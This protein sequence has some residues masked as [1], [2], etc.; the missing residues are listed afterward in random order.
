MGRDWLTDGRTHR[1][2]SA[3]RH[4][5]SGSQGRTHRTRHIAFTMFSVRTMGQTRVSSA[6]SRSMY[7]PTSFTPSRHVTS[8]APPCRA[9][10]EPPFYCKILHLA[11]GG[12]SARGGPL[13]DFHPARSSRSR[14]GIVSAGGGGVIFL[15]GF[16]LFPPLQGK[17]EQMQT[18]N[19]KVLGGS[20][21]K[22]FQVVREIGAQK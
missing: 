19:Q 16:A 2:R 15:Y 10:A 9:L 22:C 20:G 21:F 17:T 12:Q 1:T 7:S 5:G 11:R 13:L 14:S 18:T 6:S 4:T 3:C 8:C